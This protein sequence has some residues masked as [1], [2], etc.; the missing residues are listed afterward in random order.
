[1]IRR[2][3]LGFALLASGAHAAPRVEDTLAQRLQACTGCHGA[4]GRAAS[5]GYYPR[6]AGKPAGYLYNQLLSSVS[7]R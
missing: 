1:M 3:V 7:A 5:D 6:I 2:L 4:Q